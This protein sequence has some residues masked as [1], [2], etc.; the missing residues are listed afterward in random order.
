MDNS[1]NNKN[2]AKIEDLYSEL[3]MCFSES[4]CDHIKA[5]S[6]LNSIIERK[7][8]LNSVPMR[9]RYV[10]FKKMLFHYVKSADQKECNYDEINVI[11]IEK[12]IN[13]FNPE[14]AL[15]LYDVFKRELLRSSYSE[16]V[17]ELRKGIDLTKLK[18]YSA[19]KGVKSWIKWLSIRCSYRTRYLVFMLIGTFVFLNLI[20]LSNKSISIFKFSTIQ[21]SEIHFFNHLGNVMI[22]I[23]DLNDGVK[24]EPLNFIG[25]LFMFLGK[26]VFMLF[27]VNFVLKKILDK[28]AK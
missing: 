5:T 7:K 24:V 23:L 9:S 21:I 14:Q 10:D 8:F 4:G 19:Q 20:L 1:R 13:E 16:K 12:K 17:E 26:V 28:L 25:V 18:V 15:Q 2:L 6:I 11:Q 27:I 3:N 22:Y